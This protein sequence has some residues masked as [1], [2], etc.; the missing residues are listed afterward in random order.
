MISFLLTTLLSVSGVAQADSGA[1]ALLRSVGGS[2]PTKN[3]ATDT[4]QAANIFVQDDLKLTDPFLIQFYSSF[5]ADQSTP[6]EVKTWVRKITRHEFEAAA[7]LWSVLQG[8]F[9]QN[10][11]NH[12]DAAQ[13][14]L[15]YQ[16]NL[17]QSFVSFW[18]EKIQ[19]DA[20]SK[21]PISSILEQTLASQGFDAWMMKSSV[22]FDPTQT[23]QLMKLDSNRSSMVL[24]LQA[25][26]SLRKGLEGEKVLALLSDTHPLKVDLAKT[27]SLAYAKKGD[28]AMAARILKQDVEPILERK[29]DL[30]LLSNY[31]L[32]IARL[33]YQAG[34]MD[35]A[36]AFYQKIPNGAPEYLTAQEEL[37]WV[38]LRDGA[39]DRL[40]GH[41]VTLGSKIF[42]ERFQPEVEL[43]RSIS[44]L[45]MCY[46]GDVESDFRSFSTKNREF[47][48]AIDK[49]LNSSEVPV[50]AIPDPF[51]IRAREALS[52]RDSE[53][54]RLK[55]LSERS[56][57]AV[58]P[59]VGP[60]SHWKNFETL[61]L[62]NQEDAKKTLQAEYRR[63]WNTQHTALQEAIRKMQFVKVE[64]L[65]ELALAQLG[66]ATDQ[67]GTSQSSP[68]L[69]QPKQLE[70]AEKQQVYPFDGVVW[71]DEL[72]KL[73]S[74]TR[75]KCLGQ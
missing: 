60:Q 4:T 54:S 67:V 52:V 41:L 38:W 46:Y 43:V 49:G 23:A 22:Q 12:A 56:I 72:F 5:S 29:K 63:Q 3:T 15:L 64:L 68:L 25:L 20:F 28:L 24:S 30:K 75:G 9:P 39:T 18:L 13:A 19:S 55:E 62:K 40:R 71:S 45:K 32:Q 27:V 66:Q 57:S 33:L 69:I 16:L 31:Y 7:H 21:S 8:K 10:L 1:D 34:S 17:P 70:V 73:R 48:K 61:L 11:Q 47:A 35:G 14:Y 59:A 44:N 74:V 26:A 36:A 51:T 6:F 53:L 37:T 65:S 50:V 42:N 2:V 58:L